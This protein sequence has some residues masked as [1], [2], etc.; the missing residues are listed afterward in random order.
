LL[1]L[2]QDQTHSNNPDYLTWN[3]ALWHISC[4][5]LPSNS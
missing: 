2:K 1:S 4:W 5:L 3:K